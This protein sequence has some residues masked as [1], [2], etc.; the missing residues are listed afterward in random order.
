MDGEVEGEGNQVNVTKGRELVPNALAGVTWAPLVLGTS[1]ASGMGWPGPRG[2]RGGSPSAEGTAPKEK[3]RREQAGGN[4]G[5]PSWAGL[6]SGSSP[7]LFLPARG[8]LSK[9]QTC[10]F[11]PENQSVRVGQVLKIGL[12]LDCVEKGK[13]GGA[14]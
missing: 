4:R 14:G 7:Y 9:F 13:P 3:G 6:D 8:S 11:T 10:S 5:G 1:C 12:M 2:Y